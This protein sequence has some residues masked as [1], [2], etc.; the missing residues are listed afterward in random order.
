MKHKIELHLYGAQKYT[1]FNII[2]LILFFF[3]LPWYHHSCIIPPKKTLWYEL[4]LLLTYFLA[5]LINDF[6]TNVCIK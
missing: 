4:F 3:H 1:V 5:F 2:E 6:I